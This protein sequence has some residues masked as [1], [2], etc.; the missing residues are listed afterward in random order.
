LE[1]I[2][3]VKENMKKLALVFVFAVVASVIGATAVSAASGFAS[4]LIATWDITIAAPGQ[5]LAGTLKIEKDGE[6]LKGS[7]IT[8]LGLAPMKNITIKDDTFNADITVDVQGQTMEGKISGKLESGTISGNFE[9]P[10][11]GTIPYSG[12]KA[13]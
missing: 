13:E 8:D 3:G 1:Y 6:A 10:G 7:V 4:D 5:S 9:L 11:L 12:K 2:F